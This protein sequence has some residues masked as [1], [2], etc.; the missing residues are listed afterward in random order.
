MARSEGHRPLVHALFGSV[1][2]L[3][4]AA[5]LLSPSRGDE[6]RLTLAAAVLAGG[7][8]GCA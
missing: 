1:D 7:L 2:G 3:A 4:L 5:W 6:N 8:G